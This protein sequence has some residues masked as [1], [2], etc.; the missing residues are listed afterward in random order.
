MNKPAPPA[1]QASTAQTLAAEALLDLVPDFQQ[2]DWRPVLRLARAALQRLLPWLVPLAL[3]TAWQ[4]ASSQGWLS[5]RVLPAPLSVLDAAWQLA[6]SGEL[7]KH[8]RISAARALLGLAIGG[9]LGLVLGLLT[10]S[11]R[12]L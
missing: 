8:V 10:G 3:V 11:V 4:V 2:M 12:W 6:E 9:G 7:W 5:T 1:P